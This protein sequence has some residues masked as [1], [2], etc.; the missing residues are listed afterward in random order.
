MNAAINRKKRILILDL[1]SSGKHSNVKNWKTNQELRL[2]STTVLVTQVLSLPA[3][4]LTRDLVNRKP[5]NFLYVKSVK[6]QNISSSYLITCGKIIHLLKSLLGVL[7]L[8]GQT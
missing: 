4:N 3:S 1:L 5:V 2:L 8:E 7:E 6:W